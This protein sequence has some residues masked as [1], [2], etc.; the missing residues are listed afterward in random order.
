MPKV[1]ILGHHNTGKSHFLALL[2]LH[3]LRL[4]AQ[5]PGVSVSLE[6]PATD[7]DLRTMAHELSRGNQL[8]PTYLD[9]HIQPT[10]LKLSYRGFIFRKTR[11][12][13]LMDVAGELLR[14]AMTPLEIDEGKIQASELTLELGHLGTDPESL[15]TLYEDLFSADAYVLVV[16]LR[17]ELLEHGSSSVNPSYSTL[18]QNITSYRQAHGLG[19][20]KNIAVLFSHYDTTE[21]QLSTE[22]RSGVTA[23]IIANYVTPFLVNEITARI[24]KRPE[25]FISYTK[26]SESADDHA[27]FATEIDPISGLRLPIYPTDTYDDVLRWLRSI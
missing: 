11:N 12:L 27:A 19:E 4:A 14:P 2:Y 9:A 25:I 5:Q 22:L 15:N 17:S 3:T 23:D 8:P 21:K 16:N 13:S 24:R 1:S 26:A 10:V 7:F 18:L 6:V 20:P